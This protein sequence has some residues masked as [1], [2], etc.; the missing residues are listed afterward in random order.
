M[1]SAEPTADRQ[2]QQT[3]MSVSTFKS[4]A[5]TRPHRPSWTCYDQSL[6]WNK[7]E[8]KD[9][10]N[11]QTSICR[12]RRPYQQSFIRNNSYSCRPQ[13]EGSFC[14]RCSSH[15]QE[16]VRQRSPT[17][18]GP[19]ATSLNTDKWSSCAK[20][21]TTTSLSQC[22]MWV[23]GQQDVHCPGCNIVLLAP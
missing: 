20:V 15:E 6:S 5:E 2:Q 18:E 12:R 7:W 14:W 10:I 4:P 11:Q 17:S 23:S 16:A 8:I 21:K 1:T 19:S 22:F 9:N 13:G 3:H